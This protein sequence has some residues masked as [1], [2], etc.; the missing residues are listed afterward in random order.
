MP[1]WGWISV[2]ALLLTA[3]LACVDAEFYLVFLGVAALIVGLAGIAG[4]ESPGWLQWLA[5]A[6]LSVASM[7]ALA[8][9]IVGDTGNG[10]SPGRGTPSGTRPSGPNG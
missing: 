3:E 1:W 7:L 8:T 5:F 4:A 10:A 6:A 2:A 9:R